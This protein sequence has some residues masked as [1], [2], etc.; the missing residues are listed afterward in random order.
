MV[1]VTI[2][3]EAAP[4][5]FNGIDIPVGPIVCW[6]PSFATSL[7]QLASRFGSGKDTE[8]FPRRANKD[9]SMSA[10]SALVIEGANIT[11]K[12]LR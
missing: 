10:R 12:K 7:S 9:I 5:T 6:S 11:I 3:G 1:G 8:A 2:K 4:R